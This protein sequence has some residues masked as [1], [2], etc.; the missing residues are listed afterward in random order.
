VTIQSLDHVNIRSRRYEESLAFYRDV[1]GLDVRPAPGQAD[2][3]ASAWAYTADGRPA[4]HLNS[5]ELIPDF[6][7]EGPT[8][9]TPEGSGRVH[10]V[11]LLCTDYETIRQRLEDHGQGLRFNSVE[12][13]NLRQIFVQDPDG[14]LVEL[15]FFG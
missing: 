8:P 2:C 5:A 6:L 7:N 13:A 12:A 10:H 3:H 4:L 15:N 1:L 11:A 14:V 9:P